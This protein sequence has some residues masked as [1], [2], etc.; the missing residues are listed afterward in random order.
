MK[1]LE[2]FQNYI[3]ELLS[4]DKNVEEINARMGHNKRDDLL[5]GLGLLAFI[6]CMIATIVSLITTKSVVL[7]LFMGI[8]C[9]AGMVCF[10]IGIIMKAKIAKGYARI[11]IDYKWQVI[12]FLFGDMVY[13]YNQFNFIYQEMF[14]QGTGINRYRID[15]YNGEDYLEVNIPNDDGSP[16][17]NWLKMS[18]VLAE[19]KHETK[20]KEGNVQVYYET[21]FSGMFGFIEFPYFFKNELYINCRPLSRKSCQKMKLED[22]DFNNKFTL[23]TDDQI[24]GRYILTT[25]LM[26]KL[27][28]L[29]QYA[30]F[31][32][33]M[34]D[35]YLYITCPYKHLFEFSRNVK[36]VQESFI[37]FYRDY[38]AIYSIIT[39]IA[40][41]N[42]VFKI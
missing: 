25:E 3:N 10:I 15:R 38:L 42:K 31:T 16:S 13:R 24:E 20:D 11:G 4:N 33:A 12:A 17:G 21:L 34:T 19:E 27:K 26:V 40:G 39:E 30:Y 14:T 18:D 28:K 41:N 7:G 2:E 6:I 9:I 32:F 5:I 36:T 37:S 1:S 23:Y 8:L 22:V 29:A 35:K